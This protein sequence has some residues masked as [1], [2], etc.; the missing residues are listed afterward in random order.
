MIKSRLPPGFQPTYEE[1]KQ[2]LKRKKGVTVVGFQPTYEELKQELPIHDFV[3]FLKVFSLPTRNWNSAKYRRCK[4]SRGFSAYLRGIETS[5]RSLAISTYFKV[6]SLPTR[7]WNSDNEF[8]TGTPW[9]FSAYLRGIETNKYLYVHHILLLVFSLPTRNW[10]CDLLHASNIST[11]KFSAYLRGIETTFQV[12]EAERQT[13][14]FQPTYEELKPI[15]SSLVYHLKDGF[16]PT[17]EELKHKLM[18]NL[19]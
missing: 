5:I 6:F 10:N 4:Y 3:L 16:Q 15:L 17:Y 13:I 12:V 11:N 19:Q 2:R 9:R 18:S 7:N 14:G 8:D 1:L